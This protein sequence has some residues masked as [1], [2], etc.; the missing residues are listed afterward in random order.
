MSLTSLTASE[1]ATAEKA[2][3]ADAA[4]SDVAKPAEEALANAEKT[5]HW[6]SLGFLDCL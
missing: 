5:V 1:D 4:S 6:F 3:D 2:A